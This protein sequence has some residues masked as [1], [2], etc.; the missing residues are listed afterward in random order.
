MLSTDF[1]CR[2]TFKI[3]YLLVV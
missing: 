2:E 1:H 3:D